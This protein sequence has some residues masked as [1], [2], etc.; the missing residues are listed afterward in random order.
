MLLVRF[1]YWNMDHAA[2]HVPL[3]G[4]SL[5][6]LFFPFQL[7]PICTLRTGRLLFGTFRVAQKARSNETTC[8]PRLSELVVKCEEHYTGVCR[9]LQSSSLSRIG[10]EA[11]DYCT[12]PPL[13]ARGF[14][15]R[16]MD[17]CCEGVHGQEMKAEDFFSDWIYMQSLIESKGSSLP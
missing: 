12:S 10:V 5:P 9:L 11:G 8:R 4:S 3:Q 7:V 6:T 14:E 13:Q 2:I 1:R 17:W 16:F 15:S